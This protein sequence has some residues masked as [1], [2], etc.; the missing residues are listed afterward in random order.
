MLKRSLG[1]YALNEG[2]DYVTEDDLKYL[3]P[4]VLQHRLRFHPGAGDPNEAFQELVR[5]HLEK[6]ITSVHR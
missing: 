2:R 4:F 1:A 3:A 6:L 5:P